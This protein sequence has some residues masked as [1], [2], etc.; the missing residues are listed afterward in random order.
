MEAL[1]LDLAIVRHP[2]GALT[3][4]FYDSA[5]DMT[6][7]EDRRFAI[8]VRGSALQTKKEDIEKGEDQK[9]RW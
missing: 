2:R 9:D 1:K 5:T 4:T 8:D 7:L 3:P 6:R